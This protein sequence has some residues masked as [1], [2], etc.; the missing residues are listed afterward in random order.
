MSIIKIS[1][2]FKSVFLAICIAMSFAVVDAAQSPAGA[3]VGTGLDITQT[4]YM[5]NFI[6]NAASGVVGS[7]HMLADFAYAAL[8]NGTDN[9]SPY[10]GGSG[11]TKDPSYNI[12]A[13]GLLKTM[14]SQLIG[15]DW[16]LAW[17]P[18]DYQIFGSKGQS[19]NAAFVVYSASQDT[20]ILA[21]AGTNP[22]AKFDWLLEDFL[23]GQDFLVNWPL[24]TQQSPYHPAVILPPV[25]IPRNDVVP[26]NKMISTGTANGV[27]YTLTSLVQS[28]YAP[29]STANLTLQLYLSQLKQSANGTTKLIVTGHSL[30]GALSPTIANWA[31]DTLV[32]LDPRWS[33]QVLA[34]PT[35]GPTPG[36]A[37]Y[38][39]DWDAKFP[40]YPVAVNS[41]NIVKSLNTLV[42]NYGDVVPHAWQNLYK[43]VAVQENNYYFWLFYLSIDKYYHVESQ[44]GKLSLPL[45]TTS[46]ALLGAVAYAHT[47]G[48]Q[49]G[50]TTQK[51][52]IKINDATL[53]PI[54]YPDNKNS[55]QTKSLQKLTTPITSVNDFASALGII[56]VWGYY[57]AYNID[58]ATIKNIMSVRT[59][60]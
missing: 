21:I 36:N 32:S 12:T 16:Q 5:F 20:Y 8:T 7:P 4:A 6:A 42:Y 10:Y 2:K 53:W 57:S 55:N 31:Q 47:V 59:Y 23:V 37:A 56:H 39:A 44:I 27:Y 38:A 50:M 11:T 49:A 48:S 58:L 40:K 15:G 26:T 52:T 35:A 28:Q 60:Q 29:Q 41:G 33:G 46:T 34:M 1:M 54:Q 18:G 30:G 22:S 43:E 14:G 19:D 9:P 3:S 17:G 51:N 24:T 45:D 25:T 13:P